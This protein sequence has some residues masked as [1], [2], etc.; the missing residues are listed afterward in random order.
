MTC[1]VRGQGRVAGI[2]GPPDDRAVYEAFI[3][4]GV[5]LYFHEHWSKVANRFKTTIEVRKLAKAV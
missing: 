5:P 4:T 1:S 3:D 2:G